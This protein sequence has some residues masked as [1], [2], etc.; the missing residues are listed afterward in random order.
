[1]SLHFLHVCVRFVAAGKPEKKGEI[2]VSVDSQTIWIIGPQIAVPV[3]LEGLLPSQRTTN[4]VPEKPISIRIRTPK[5][6]RNKKSANPQCGECNC[7]CNLPM[8]EITPKIMPKYSNSQ[9]DQS[10]RFLYKVL[11]PKASELLENITYNL[12]NAQVPPVRLP[13]TT[14]G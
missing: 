4:P 10:I 1:M 13:R 7:K 6:T 3:P 12:E 5:W 11:W 9:I 2:G 8:G 14:S